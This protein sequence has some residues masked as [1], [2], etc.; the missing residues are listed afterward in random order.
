MGNLPCTPAIALALLSTAVL[1]CAP[2]PDG[3]QDTG[4]ST[5]SSAQG[6]ELV[7]AALSCLYP[8]TL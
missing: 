1:C 6:A 2:L 7:E 8:V 4:C 3:P 5:D